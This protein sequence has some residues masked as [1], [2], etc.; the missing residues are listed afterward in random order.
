MPV[1]HPAAAGGNLLGASWGARQGLAPRAY[2]CRAGLSLEPRKL[3]CE[4]GHEWDPSGSS[5][6]GGRA[7]AHWRRLSGSTGRG[8]WWCT[9]RSRA[10]GR[11]GTHRGTSGA[12]GCD[13]ERLGLQ[14]DLCDDRGRPGEDGGTGRWHGGG[15]ISARMASARR[16]VAPSAPGRLWLGRANRLRGSLV[17]AVAAEELSDVGRVDAVEVQVH[18]PGASIAGRAASGKEL[19]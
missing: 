7:S 18:L 3:A 5:S 2:S 1:L 10:A 14:A 11:P 4:H 12:E 15:S 16:G 13:P 8:I 9:A 19:P 17:L 6:P